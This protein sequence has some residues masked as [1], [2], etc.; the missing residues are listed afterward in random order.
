MWIHNKFLACNSIAQHC[1]E[2][3]HLSHVAIHTQISLHT[4]CV[5]HSLSFKTWHT[6]E[7]HAKTTMIFPFPVFQLWF[8]CCIRFFPSY[9]AE[10]LCVFFRKKKPQMNW[11]G[12]FFFVLF[13]LRF[14]IIFYC[15]F[16]E[17]FLF[18]FCFSLIWF[19]RV[20]LN[21]SLLTYKVCLNKHVLFVWAC[22]NVWLHVF[23][24]AIEY[25]LYFCAWIDRQFKRDTYTYTI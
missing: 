19:S 12:E 14:Q 4:W 18:K 10:V 20:C 22:M 8:V 1:S 11:C 24:I 16:P 6:R 17:F 13:S 25:I 23:I 15:F 21:H 3:F 2:A 5:M 9:S 7:M